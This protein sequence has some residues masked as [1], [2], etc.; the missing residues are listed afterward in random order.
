MD[1]S[2]KPAQR[3][4]TGDV[5]KITGQRKQSQVWRKKK[6]NVRGKKEKKKNLSFLGV[7]WKKNLE[8]KE[9]TIRRKK[10]VPS[11]KTVLF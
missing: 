3:G 1:R 10:G 11:E 6:N 4:K 7:R 9:R 5:A 2:S 8:T